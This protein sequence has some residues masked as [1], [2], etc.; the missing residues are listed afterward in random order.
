MAM[1]TGP[2]AYA[3]SATPRTT[4]VTPARIATEK[5][6]RSREPFARNVEATE[7]VRSGGRF[8][9]GPSDAQGRVAFRPPAP[10]TDDAL[11]TQPPLVVVTRGLAAP[12]DDGGAVGP[13]VVEDVQALAGLHADDRVDACECPLL[14]G[15][16]AAAS[17]LD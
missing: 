14:V 17:N 7:K 15:G 8:G 6:T 2:W 10:A 13:E 3:G 1:A 16:T 4:T 5:R 9:S 11:L 12:Q